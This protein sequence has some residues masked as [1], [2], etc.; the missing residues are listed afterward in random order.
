MAG[1]FRNSYTLPIPDD[2]KPVTVNG[3]PSMK[4]KKDGKEVVSPL[5]KNGTRIRVK[6][7]T[8]YGWV[9]GK[10]VKL[11]TDKK[12]SQI[13]LS[14]LI[15]KAER[16]EV[17]LADRFEKHRTRP[18]TEHVDDWAANL[19]HTGKTSAH[20]AATKSCVRRIIEAC[21]F[22]RIGDISASRVEKYLASLRD[23]SPVNQL[24]PAK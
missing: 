5:N 11:F 16:Q 20:A 1:L 2:A 21:K 8:W 12:A 3:V 17:G 6:N 15:R 22:E 7:P 4:Y 13:R 9:N 24:D 14:E 23:D 19:L 18:L 10:A